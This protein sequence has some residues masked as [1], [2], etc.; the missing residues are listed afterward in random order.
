MPFSNVRRRTLIFS[1]S[2]PVVF[3]PVKKVREQ[4]MSPARCAHPQRRRK[5]RP[6]DVPGDRFE[7][8]LPNG[9]P[10]VQFC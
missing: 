4:I 7:E 9:K 5:D 10:L 6:V 8:M 2:L 1:D 3:N